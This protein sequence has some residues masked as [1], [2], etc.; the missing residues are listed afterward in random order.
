[1][2]LNFCYHVWWVCSLLI[3]FTQGIAC[4]KEKA[5]CFSVFLHTS[6]SA[7]A[8]AS[9]SPLIH[10][11]PKAATITIQ[12]VN[13]SR[14]RLRASSVLKYDLTTCHYHEKSNALRLPIRLHQPTESQNALRPKPK[15]NPDSKS[16]PIPVACFLI[17]HQF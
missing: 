15:A 4:L 11:Q 8:S 5:S 2:S 10:H 17:L 7:S 16:Q 13:P 1:M 9:A 3:Q 6:P 14:Q 12:P